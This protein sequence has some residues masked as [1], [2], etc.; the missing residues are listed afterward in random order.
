MSDG[1]M[2][3]VSGSSF[4]PFENTMGKVDIGDI[5]WSLAHQC[6]YN[7]HVDRFYSVANHCI[8][9]ARYFYDKRKYK[10]ALE[11]LLH[12][13]SEAYLGD[14]IY[15]VKQ[16]FPDFLAL[17]NRV[18]GYILSQLGHHEFTREEDG[19]IYYKQ[20]KEVRKLDRDM[21]PHETAIL[22]S[23]LNGAQYNKDIGDLCDMPPDMIAG[24]YEIVYEQLVDKVYD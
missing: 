8:V 14:M 7:G 13:A 6:R 3:T 19:V 22:R 5:A 16:L 2:K 11:A 23:S 12:D 20:S 4:C 17:E 24:Q 1:V 10:L 9:M 21:I 18:Q 15:P